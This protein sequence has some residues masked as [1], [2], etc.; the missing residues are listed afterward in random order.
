MNRYGKTETTMRLG[1]EKNSY[2]GYQ[3][4]PPQFPRRRPIGHVPPPSSHLEYGGGARLGNITTVR[5]PVYTILRMDAF[6]IQFDR[7]ISYHP[8]D[9]MDP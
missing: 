5:Y 2:S 1:S 3:A 8:T 7:A 4:A 6:G 9:R